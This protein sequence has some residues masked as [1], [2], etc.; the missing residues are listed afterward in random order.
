MQSPNLVHSPVRQ[1]SPAARKGQKHL[2]K[3]LDL[4]S[5]DQC[6]GA[7]AGPGWVLHSQHSGTGTELH[8]HPHPLVSTPSCK[9]HPPPRR[10]KPQGD[11]EQMPG[12]CS[13][14]AIP[15]HDPTFLE[16]DSTTRAS[17]MK[18]SV[19]ASLSQPLQ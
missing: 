3:E 1:G 11:E 16:K 8:P 12:A 9:P 17:S 6:T 14:L 7:Q 18:L 2:V 19:G 4:G 10:C 15:H 5:A 13:E